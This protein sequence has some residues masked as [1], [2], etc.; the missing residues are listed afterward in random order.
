[1]L[2]RWQSASL[3]VHL[4][5]QSL[6]LALGI[7]LV[8]FLYPSVQA[9]NSST[10]A[11]LQE[12]A[13]VAR[14]MADRMDAIRTVARGETFLYPSVAT[15][16]LEQV[17]DSDSSNGKCLTPREKEIVKHIAAG[18]TNPQIA[19]ALGLSVKTVDGTASIS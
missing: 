5:V 3:R 12:R 11:A 17:Q 15:T 14:L 16:V 19:T 10:Q 2:R 8:V 7:I 18:E 13:V 4:L 9:L 6:S 1:M